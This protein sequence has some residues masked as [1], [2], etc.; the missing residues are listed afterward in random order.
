MEAL[1]GERTAV[2]SQAARACVDATCLVTCAP[3]RPTFG[4]RVTFRLG[5]HVAKV[6]I[7]HLGKKTYDNLISA[8]RYS[9]LRSKIGRLP[10]RCGRLFGSRRHTHGARVYPVCTPRRRGTAVAMRSMRGSSKPRP[11]AVADTYDG[12]GAHNMQTHLLVPVFFLSTAT[13]C[14]P[15]PEV[16][17]GLLAASGR[18]REAVRRQDDAPPRLVATHPPAAAGLGRQRSLFTFESKGEDRV[19]SCASAWRAARLRPAWP[20]N[21]RRLA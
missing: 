13:R 5:F 20:R 19:P 9:L 12:T 10:M 8:F 17:P 15:R 1:E 4:F 6:R 21:A 16:P 18:M 2:S 7:R 3:S 11:V 14:H